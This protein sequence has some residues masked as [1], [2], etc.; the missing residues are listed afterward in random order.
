MSDPIRDFLKQQEKEQ[1][2]QQQPTQAQPPSDPIRKQLYAQ[3]IK[4]QQEAEK[5]ERLESKPWYQSAA[6]GIGALGE[7]GLDMAASGVSQVAEGYVGIQNEAFNK[8]MQKSVE[9]G[10]VS[11]EFA[12]QASGF[13]KEVYSPEKIAG[14]LDYEPK[15]DA[16]KEG[17]EKLGSMAKAVGIDKIAE[18]T[19]ASR[20]FAG[21]AV[22]EKTNS[23]AAASL[24]YIVPDIAASY[25]S[26]MIPSKNIP[27]NSPSAKQVQAELAKAEINPEQINQHVK[28]LYR[29]IDDMGVKA[30]AGSKAGMVD[31]IE[32]ALEKANI[33]PDLVGMGPLLRKLRKKNEPILSRQNGVMVKQKESLTD[34]DNIRQ[35]LAR[36]YSTGPVKDPDLVKTRAIG[37]AKSAIDD[38]MFEVLPS[39]LRGSGGK[40]VFNEMKER[41]NVA[42]M[43]SS[44]KNKFE[45]INDVFTNAKYYEATRYV[46]KIQDQFRNILQNKQKVK[47]YSDKEKQ[48]MTDVASGKDRGALLRMLERFNISGEYISRSLTNA[49]NKKS[50]LK[51]LLGISFLQ[52]AASTA[53]NASQKK[54][55][56][57]AETLK[58]IAAS[59]DSGE[60]IV[61]A[62]MKA[63]PKNKRDYVELGD[64]LSDPRVNLDDVI[65]RKGAMHEKAIEYAKGRRRILSALGT[66]N[67][68]GEEEDEQIY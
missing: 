52:N 61:R 2:S 55:K 6:E 46:S 11:P 53:V 41:L 64:L 32:R 20:E 26:K 44:R 38:F 39:K 60:D 49:N 29:E 22:Y 63:V 9:A 21:D 28:E 65:A 31:Y 34:F 23:P 57:K 18:L 35:A 13:L 10:K 47:W 45:E 43:A 58:R 3:N 12:K 50:F 37:I 40:A 54:I 5:K 56:A 19:Q 17:Y 7:A 59:G 16:T 30:P 27:K 36:N 68:D 67:L 51:K 48:L 1:Q 14:A 33:D 24:A 62:Y 8:W 15:L 42:R 4:V 66:T 25:F